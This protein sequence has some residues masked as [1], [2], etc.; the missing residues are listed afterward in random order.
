LAKLPGGE[1]LSEKQNYR[2]DSGEIFVTLQLPKNGKTAATPVAV[3]HQQPTNLPSDRLAIRG[4]FDGSRIHY[5]LEKFYM[6]ET[7]AAKVNQE[8]GSSD[9]RRLLVEVKIDRSGH[10]ALVGL[11]VGDKKYDF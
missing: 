6:P 1:I 9:R 10:P 8:V 5:D 7:Q 11:W 4:A 2:T 3:S